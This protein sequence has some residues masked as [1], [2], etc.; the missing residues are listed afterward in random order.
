MPR[1]F[2]S[3]RREIRQ[4]FEQRQVALLEAFPS[5][6]VDQFDDAQAMVAVAHGHGHDRPR[7]HLCLFI[8]LG[9]E[10]GVLAYVG[11][12]HGFIVLR[13][14]AGN[15]LPHLDTHILQRLRTLS[16]RQLKI[17]LLFHFVDEQ[18]RP[19][20][21]TQE[22][23][24]FFHDRAQNL[25]ELQGGG[26]SL[27]QFVENR[28]FACFALLAS[29]GSAATPLDTTEILC[30]VHLT[31]LVHIRLGSPAVL[32]RAR[33]PYNY[34][35]LFL[36]RNAEFANLFPIGE[37]RANWSSECAHPSRLTPPQHPPIFDWTGEKT[38][39]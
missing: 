8:H 26:K 28:Y 29:C 4:S 15:S 38:K 3:D 39:K 37:V 1:V 16:D 13:H 5:N 12:D 6:A 23:V 14:P 30:I 10:P 24:D 21:R 17:K 32:G 7:L 25:I 2:E 36:L 19:S 31:P 34:S 27:A 22:L 20:V 11:H 33:G 35:Q 18:E 9:E